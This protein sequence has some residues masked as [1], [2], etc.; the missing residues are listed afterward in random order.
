MKSKIVIMAMVLCLVSPGVS[1]AFDPQQGQTTR[2]S[3]DV[4]LFLNTTEYGSAEVAVTVPI[5]AAPNWVPRISR[6]TYLRYQVRV[7]ERSIAGL[8]SQSIV[9]SNAPIVDGQYVVPAGE[10]YTFTLMSLVTIPDQIAPT[11]QIDLSLRVTNDI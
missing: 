6:E 3:D 1:H 9:L 8:D 2:V 5:A 10:S 4:W 7:G 11:E